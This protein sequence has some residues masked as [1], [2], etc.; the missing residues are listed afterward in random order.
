MG[1]ELKRICITLPRSLERELEQLKARYYEESESELLRVLLKKGMDEFRAEDGTI[2]LSGDESALKSSRPCFPVPVELPTDAKL[3]PFGRFYVCDVEEELDGGIRKV[4][5]NKVVNEES[6]W[7]SG[8]LTLE[9]ILYIEHEGEMLAFRMDGKILKGRKPVQVGKEYFIPIALR[10]VKSVSD[11]N[12]P[13]VKCAL[14]APYDYFFCCSTKRLYRYEN[15]FLKP[16]RSAE[17]GV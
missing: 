12:E 11:T 17:R 1:T 2:Y 16:L 15:G 5:V 10:R 9:N 3:A 4:R 13:C 7:T 6:V 8:F 14:N